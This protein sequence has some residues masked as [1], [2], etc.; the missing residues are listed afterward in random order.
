MDRSACRCETATSCAA[1]RRNIRPGCCVFR[2]H[3][4]KYSAP[5]S[6]GENA[7]TRPLTLTKPRLYTYQ[8]GDKVKRCFLQVAIILGC[9]SCAFVQTKPAADLIIQNAR[10]WTVDPS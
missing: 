6:S 5:S 7:D 10:V 1:S 4:L 9:A 2:K 3:F 8:S